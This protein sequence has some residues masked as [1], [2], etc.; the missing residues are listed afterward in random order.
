MSVT[1]RHILEAHKSLRGTLRLHQ[2]R[3]AALGLRKPYYV[4]RSAGWRP[5]RPFALIW[6]FRG[7]EREWV[8]FREDPSR[9]ESTAI[10]DLDALVLRKM[11]PPCLAVMPGLTSS[12]NWVPSAGVNMSGKWAPSMKGLGTGR[13]FDYLT[14][15]L[16]PHV[17][18]AFNRE[19]K[20]VRL[21]FG[22]SLGGFTTQLLATSMP[23]YLHHAAIYDGLFMWPGHVD[24]RLGEDGGLDPVWT[25]GAIF[26]AAFGKPRD[27]HA[28]DYWNQTDLLLK[29]DPER[30]RL[31]Q[32][33]SYW[34][35]SASGDGSVGN[36][37][38][39]AFL[40]EKLAERE[41]PNRMKRVPFAPDAQHNWHWNDAFFNRVM[42]RALTSD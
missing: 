35:N 25:K 17:E 20:A 39:T 33:T 31:M 32:K 8:N 42:V 34:I 6:L 40:I 21:A 10:Q 3:S 14:G 27:M 37:D 38:R 22:F 1:S 26:D 15:E 23:G 12:N 36:I 7:H 29:D 5:D 11:L 18:N 13:F 41:M 19:R 4:Y 30:L 9:Q 28:L 16:I 2:F 24:P